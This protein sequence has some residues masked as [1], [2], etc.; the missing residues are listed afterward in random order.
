MTTDTNVAPNDRAEN[1][2][3]CDWVEAHAD[4]LF[5]FAIGQVRDASVAE[6]LLQETF[7]AAL[8]ARDRFAGNSSERT[9]S[10]GFSGTRSAITSAVPA[11]NARTAPS[12]ESHGEDEPWEDALMWL[13]DVAAES[14]SPSRRLELAE[15]RANLELALG[16]LRR[17]LRKFSSSTK[18]KNGQTPRSAR[19]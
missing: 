11:A 2:P 5:N 10:S 3:G 13:H 14:Q 18:W 19:S 15:F 9:G 6:D 4:Y 7:L 1:P 16:K 12:A 8:K 17:A